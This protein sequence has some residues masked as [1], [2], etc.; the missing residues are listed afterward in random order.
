VLTEWLVR[1]LLLVSAQEYSGGKLAATRTVTKEGTYG[2][3]SHRI[4][5]GYFGASVAISG[6]YAVVGE[7]S[8]G[9]IAPGAGAAY[10]YHRKGSA[11][12]LVEK[13]T[14][15]D[16]ALFDGLGGSVA[17][18]GLGSAE[19]IVG[20]KGKGSGAAYV[21]SDFPEKFDVLIDLSKYTIYAKILFGLTGGGSGVIWLPGVGPVPG[22][23]GALQSFLC[24]VDDKARRSARPAIQ[25]DGESCSRRRVT[26]R[27]AEGGARDVEGGRRSD[28]RAGEDRR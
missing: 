14:A 18:Y 17:I 6:A 22:R 4:G 7:P 13:I 3:T 12:P 28:T 15:S 20:A 23:P 11:W 10:V 16:A 9:D 1:T 25:R 2:N 26:R 8:D 19:A 27:S 21:L 24:T 5:R